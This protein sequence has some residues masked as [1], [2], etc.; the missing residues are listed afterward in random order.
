MELGIRLSF[1]KTSE[2]RGGFEHPKPPPRYATDLGLKTGPLCP[3]FC[4]KLKEPF[5]FS[6]DPDGPYT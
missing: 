3:M 5:S 1:V 2:F 4:T 6:K